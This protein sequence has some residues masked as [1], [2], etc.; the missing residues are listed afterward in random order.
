MGAPRVS[1]GSG[2]RE[3]KKAATRAALRTATVRLYRRHG[4]DA[5]TVEDICAEVEVSPRTF[6]NY[7]NAKDEALFG[8]DQQ[9]SEE[10]ATEV[11]ERPTDEDAIVATRAVLQRIIDDRAGTGLWQEQM[12]L[13]REYPELLPRLHAATRATEQALAAGIAQ[14]TGRVVADPFVRTASAV[15][16]TSMR[17]ATIRWLDSPE[18]VKP[19]SLLTETVD[20]IRSGLSDPPAAHSPNPVG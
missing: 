13:L 3:R 16:M 12:L 6:F 14:R 19:G 9:Q 20:M 8:L 10:L 7:F 4:P 2:L 18:G 1:P 5:V 15:A 17:V 11:A